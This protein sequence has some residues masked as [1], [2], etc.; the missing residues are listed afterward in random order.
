MTTGRPDPHPW[1]IDLAG[2]NPPLRWEEVFGFQPAGVEIEIGSGKGLFLRGQAAEHPDVGFLGIERAAKF[3]RL[4]VERAAR[5]RRPNIRFIRADAFD[6][7]ARWVLLGSVA[8]LHVYFPDPWPKKRHTKR[9]LLGRALFDLAARALRPGGRILVATDVVPYFEEARAFLT[10]HAC[11]E[12]L[13]VSAADSEAV[14]T[15]YAL[16]YAR[17]GR[18]FRL[19]SFRRNASPP[20]P[21][22]PPP[23][24]RSVLAGTSPPRGEDA[25]P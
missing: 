22:P 5:D 15:N 6:L 1:L 18:G 23:T 14:R 9:R 2:M 25:A 16:K 24:R 7:L 10:E 11:F 20:P 8:T 12:E 4:S 17:E 21:I 13:P 3:L 19:A